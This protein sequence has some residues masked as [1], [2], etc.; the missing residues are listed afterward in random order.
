MTYTDVIAKFSSRNKNMTIDKYDIIDWVNECVRG[1]GNLDNCVFFKGVELTVANKTAL[2]PCNFYK[3]DYLFKNG[4]PFSLSGDGDFRVS[5]DKRINFD[6][7]YTNI[8]IDYYGLLL[9]D[10]GYVAIENE[11]VAEACYWYC[12]VNYMLDDYLQGLVPTDRWKFVNDMKDATMSEAEGSMK[13]WN[14]NRA[15]RMMEIMF[16]LKPKF[17]TP[18]SI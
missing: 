5:G 15:N 1:I 2:L 12:L 7:D 10:E 18:R 14:K 6:D 17:V 16:N 9:D 13:K 3:L 11:Q 4:S 8:T